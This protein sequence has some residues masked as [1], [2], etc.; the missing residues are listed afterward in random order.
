MDTR[1]TVMVSA[2]VLS[3]CDMPAGEMDACGT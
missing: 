1:V 3:S 2:W